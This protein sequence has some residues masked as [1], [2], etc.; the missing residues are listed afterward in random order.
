MYT[1]FQRQ[2]AATA[3]KRTG[4]HTKDKI[5]FGRVVAEVLPRYP[6]AGS[7]RRQREGEVIDRRRQLLNLPSCSHYSVASFRV[8][9]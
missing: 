1:T 5:D 6:G 8:G 7:F 4:H 2:L 9:K 3:L